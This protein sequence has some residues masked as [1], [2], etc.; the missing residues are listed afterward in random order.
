VF[1]GAPFA[2]LL[3][4]LTSACLF[5]S[6][7]LPSL[8]YNAEV[9]L[10]GIP[11]WYSVFWVLPVLSISYGILIA[12]SSILYAVTRILRMGLG[13]TGILRFP[14][15]VIEHSCSHDVVAQIHHFY[16]DRLMLNSISSLDM[17]FRSS[18]S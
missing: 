17:Q 12:I 8:T 7:I 3:V 2:I 18:C 13:W 9:F 4:A 6:I 10:L 14:R 5:Q 15:Y 1:I 11:H 16:L